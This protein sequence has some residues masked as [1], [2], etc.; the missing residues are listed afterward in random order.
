MHDKLPL[1]LTVFGALTLLFAAIGYLVYR[2]VAAPQAAVVE[3]DALR[4]PIAAG[5]SGWSGMPWLASATNSINPRLILHAD[6]I[7]C[8]VLRTRIK[9]YAAVAQ[10]DY[11]QTIGTT[12]VVLVFTDSVVTFMGNTRSKDVARRAIAYLADKGCPLSPR[13]AELLKG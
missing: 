13:A 3:G 5:F 7:E 6:R 10:V 9:P 12:N 2:I 8:R 4:V 1:V 11:R